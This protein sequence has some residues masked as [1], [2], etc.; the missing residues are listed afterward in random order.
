MIKVVSFLPRL[1]YNVVLPFHDIQCA[2]SL[3]ITFRI[4]SCATQG[5]TRVKIVY[6]RLYIFKYHKPQINITCIFNKKKLHVI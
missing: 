4:Y 3:K 2:Y 5:N 1:L 6:R